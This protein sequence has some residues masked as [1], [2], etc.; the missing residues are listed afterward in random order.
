VV[1]LGFGLRQPGSSA[2]QFKHYVMLFF[3]K[4]KTPWNHVNTAKALVAE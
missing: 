2:Y 3:I 1:E 4:K